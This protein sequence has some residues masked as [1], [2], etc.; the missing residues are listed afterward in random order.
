[1]ALDA[2]KLRIVRSTNGKTT[3]TPVPA[4]LQS[5]ARSQSLAFLAR[6]VV[7]CEGKTEEA[8]VRSLESFWAESISRHLMHLLGVVPVVQRSR[9]DAHASSRWSLFTCFQ[10]RFVL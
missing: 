3:I 2:S 5:V 7:V 6:K 8:V 9:L 4:T 1:M 10:Y